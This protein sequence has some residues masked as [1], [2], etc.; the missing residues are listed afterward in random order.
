M[1]Q[2]FRVFESLDAILKREETEADML[3]AFG[4]F[5]GTRL[6]PKS[7][8]MPGG[9]YL[10][11]DGFSL[12]PAVLCQVHSETGLFTQVQERIAIFDIIKLNY[13]ARALGNTARRVLLFRDKSTARRICSTPKV[14]DQLGDSGIEV[15]VAA[16]C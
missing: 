5:L 1:E 16:G 7:L 12:S 4:D 3:R 11:I 9:G 14:A 10:D 2:T 13:A 6:R 15:C 8:P